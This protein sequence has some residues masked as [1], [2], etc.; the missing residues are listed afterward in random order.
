[1]NFHPSSFN[2]LLSEGETYAHAGDGTLCYSGATNA[3][4]D[5]NL[6]HFP[7]TYGSIEELSSDSEVEI[8]E[9]IEIPILPKKRRSRTNFDAWQLGELERVFK[10]TQYPD[11]FTREALALK[12]DL[13]ESRVQVWFQNRRAKLRREEKTKAR[14]GRR[15]KSQVEKSSVTLKILEVFDRNLS[16]SQEDTEETNND[17]SPSSLIVGNNEQYSLSTNSFSIESILARKD[18]PLSE[19]QPPV[20]AENIGRSF[21]IDQ[22][23]DEASGGEKE[24]NAKEGK[25]SPSKPTFV[26]TTSLN[27]PPRRDNKTANSESRELENEGLNIKEKEETHKVTENLAPF[28][29]PLARHHNT[30][31]NHP[32]RY[33]P[34]EGMPSWSTEVFENFRSSSIL[35]LRT[36]AEEHLKQLRTSYVS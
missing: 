10:R 23:L 8:I 5:V 18:P 14:P 19:K 26:A 4:S 13:L 27:T 17:E 22:L 15:E 2:L 1:M 12:L 7:L 6:F 21:R 35:R 34:T 20:S 16:E 9:A 32:E 36:K 24:N 29:V 33:Q 3:R 11:V 25:C 31:Q 30:F 28:Y